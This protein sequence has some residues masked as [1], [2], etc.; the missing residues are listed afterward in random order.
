MDG[1][2]VCGGGGPPCNSS[3]VDYNGVSDAC[4]NWLLLQENAASLRSYLATLRSSLASQCS[5][6]DRGL[7]GTPQCCTPSHWNATAQ[8]IQTRACTNNVWGPQCLLPLQQL[9]Q[10]YSAAIQPFVK[11]T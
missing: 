8:N 7:Q 4:W 5:L 9:I 1:C 3:C 6:L 10:A 11:T 2:G